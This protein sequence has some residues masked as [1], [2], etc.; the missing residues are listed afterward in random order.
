[1]EDLAAE[2]I[3]AALRDASRASVDGL[4]VGNMLSG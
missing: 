3:F 1:L 2:A 4:F